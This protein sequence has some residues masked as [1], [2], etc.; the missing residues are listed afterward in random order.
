MFIYKQS[1]EIVVN[2]TKIKTP[3][4]FLKMAVLLFIIL[5]CPIKLVW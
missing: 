4:M 2:K 1:A 3:Q 5:V